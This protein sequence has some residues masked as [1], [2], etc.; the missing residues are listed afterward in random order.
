MPT[1]KFF[2]P[3]KVTPK[4]R[5]RVT[6]NGSYFPQTYQDWRSAANLEIISQLPADCELPIASCSVSISLLG[7]GH[8]GDLDNL[9]GAI[10]DALVTAGVLR[11]DRLSC[12]PLLS[13]AYQPEGKLG[14]VVELAPVGV[15]RGEG[16]EKRKDSAA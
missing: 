3:G 15:S 8:R 10:L 4:A 7:K 14:A 12:V 16:R 9:A 13:I 5:P 1:L 6:R 2:I 11:D